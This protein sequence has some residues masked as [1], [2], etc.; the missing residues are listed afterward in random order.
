[1]WLR[2]ADR[3]V[4]GVSLACL[5]LGLAVDARAQDDQRIVREPARSI[6]SPPPP[7][8][9]LSLNDYR[10]NPAFVVESDGTV[11]F[12]YAGT[13]AWSRYFVSESWRIPKY[14]DVLVLTWVNGP[15]GRTPVFLRGIEPIGSGAE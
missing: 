11:R 5:A 9:L 7:V 4:V 8:P 3:L 1:M 14:R 10:G 2:W 6:L 12:D 13:I 15:A